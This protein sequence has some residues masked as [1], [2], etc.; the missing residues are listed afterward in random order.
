MK[1]GFVHVLATLGFMM[2]PAGAIIL[3]GLD[4]SANQT[5]P[6]TGVHFDAVAKVYNTSGGDTRGSAVHIG[7]GYMLTANHVEVTAAQSF[8]FNGVDFYTLDA[9]Y[10]P[11]QVA[12]GVDMKVF[13][14]AA[15]PTVGAANLYSGVGEMVAP[16]TLVGWGR[17]RL[18]SVPIE[19]ATVTW[20]DLDTIAKRWGLNVPK[21][22]FN[23]GYTHNSI[24]YNYPSIVTVLGSETGDPAGLGANEAAL[25]Q[26]DSGS[27][28]FQYI[29]GQWYLIGIAT[30]VDT[31]GSS[32][33]GNDGFGAGGGDANYFARVGTYHTQILTLVPEPATGLMALGGVLRVLRRRRADG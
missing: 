15:I 8:T 10:T 25:T 29:G 28:L 12:T 4:N 24:T 20:G 9:G 32:T 21:A 3:F 5:D 16:A 30:T 7:G 13:R 14:L 1:S 31:N 33:F 26:Y 22:A 27:G 6:G 11:T 23:I 17:G 19:T 2:Q 18:P